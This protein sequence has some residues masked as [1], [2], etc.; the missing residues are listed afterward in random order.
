MIACFINKSKTILIEEK[1]IPSELSVSYGDFIL[2]QA[3]YEG[4]E[5]ITTLK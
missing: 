5:N 4:Q 2:K 1:G 3:F